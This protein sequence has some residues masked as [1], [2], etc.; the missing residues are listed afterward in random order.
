MSIELKK[1]RETQSAC[2]TVSQNLGL[3]QVFKK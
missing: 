3:I 1:G 2:Q